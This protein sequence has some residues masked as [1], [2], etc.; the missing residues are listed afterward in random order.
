[1]CVFSRLSRRQF[2]QAATTASLGA[3]L[4]A[5]TEALLAAPQTSW[6]VGCRDLHLK[7]AGKPDSWSC[8]R[9]L[10]ADGIEVDVALDLSCPYLVHPEHRYSLATADGIRA[11]AGDLATNNC[12]ITAFMMSNRFDE[13]L[14]EELECARRLAKAAQQLGV[15][16]VRID[17][18]PRKLKKQEFLAFAIKAC[19]QLCQTA[20]GT[21][22]RFGIENH[23]NTTNDP[24]FL[25]QLFAGVGSSRLGLTLD[26]A[27]FYWWG[28]PLDDL[29]AIYEKFAARIVHTHCKSIAYPAE[30]KSVRRQMGWEYEKYN[31]PVYQGDIDFK[32]LVAILRKANYQGDLCVEDES[33]GKFP[34]T[35][36]GEILKKEIAFLRQL[37]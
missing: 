35:E 12:R 8:M 20:E 6:P 36:R 7:T 14:E 33:L 2:I 32:R 28:H 26:C 34:E 16:A 3:G 18:V 25:D 21:D 4:F 1:M 31:C 19:K 37:A 22:V 9:A 15:K 5:Q 30:K 24:A 11:L 10:G 13:R 27:N 17:V 23:G 29:Y